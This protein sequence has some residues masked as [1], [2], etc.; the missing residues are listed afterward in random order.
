MRARWRSFIRHQRTDLA[1]DVRLLVA[2]VCHATGESI[3]ISHPIC[4]TLE[5]PSQIV[6]LLQHLR[7]FALTE[8][9]FG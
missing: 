3:P 6:L 2:F 5:I 7:G 1:L 8:I 9:Q 4:Q